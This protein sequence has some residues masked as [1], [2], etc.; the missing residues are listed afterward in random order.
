MTRSR[1]TL[2]DVAGGTLWVGSLVSA[3][4]FFGNLP[5]VSRNLSAIIWTMI[6]IPGLIIVVGALRSKGR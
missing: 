3:G 2:F 1:F 5:W 4:F 6:L